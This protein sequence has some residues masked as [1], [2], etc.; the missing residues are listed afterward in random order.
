MDL[1]II[2]VNWNSARYATACVASVRAQTSNLE[3]EVII[4]DNASTDD[5]RLILQECLPGVRLICSPR[6]LGFARANNL[7]VE[8]STGRNLLFLNPDTELRGPAIN[9]MYSCLESSP[10]V[11][12][13]GCQLLNTDLTTQTSCV[14]SYPTILNQAL[15]SERL[16]R[17][18]PQSR[19]WGMRPLY[20]SRN[21]SLENAA[22]VSGACLMIPRQIFEKVGRF[23]PDYFM[24]MEDLDLCYQVGMIGKR[25]CYLGSATII[26][27]GGQSSKKKG[28]EEF[29]GPLMRQSVFRFFQKTRGQLYARLYRATMFNVALIRLCILGGLSLLPV[30]DSRKDSQRHS[31][32]KWRKVL[33]WTLGLE[34]WTRRLGESAGQPPSA[35]SSPVPR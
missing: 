28:G 29:S 23:D 7:G 25:I 13:L 18:T 31:L 34:P 30:A 32:G 14:Q 6:N 17:L 9:L 20:E 1:S 21:G 16:R 2:I 27:H 8:S 12:I 35:N 11:G 10:D 4:V 5:S 15:D 24:Y 22:M 3:Y 19:L 26:H 33:R